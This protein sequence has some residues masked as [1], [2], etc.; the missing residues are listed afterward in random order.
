MPKHRCPAH[1]LRQELM[2]QVNQRLFEGGCITRELY[3][4]AKIRIVST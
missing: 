4:E 1:A 2:L 3:E